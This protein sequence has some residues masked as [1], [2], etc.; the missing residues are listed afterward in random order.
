MAK[1][2]KITSKFKEADIKMVNN[3]F[4]GGTR[5][6]ICGAYFDDGGFC[7]NKHPRGGEYYPKDT[8]AVKHDQA[9]KVAV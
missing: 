7:D 3:G 8:L 2:V 9:K 4:A 1:K 5:C 6:D